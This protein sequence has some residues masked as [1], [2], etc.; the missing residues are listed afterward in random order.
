MEVPDDLTD[1]VPAD[2]QLQLQLRDRVMVVPWA[3]GVVEDDFRRFVFDDVRQRDRTTLR[4]TSGSREHLLWENQTSAQLEE[5]LWLS[6]I[7]GLAEV[8]E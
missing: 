6:L 5:V 7:D 4:A 8:P 3:R 1:R 2:T